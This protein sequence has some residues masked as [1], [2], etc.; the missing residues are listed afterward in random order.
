MIFVDCFAFAKI[1][2]IFDMTMSQAELFYL[3]IH[4]NIRNF[5]RFIVYE[6]QHH[7]SK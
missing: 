7:V 2:I 5:A 1:S 3:R 4:F 6:T